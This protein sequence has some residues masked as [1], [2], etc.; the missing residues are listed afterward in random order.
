MIYDTD[1]L[2]YTKFLSGNQG[3]IINNELVWVVKKEE[4][5]NVFGQDL[6]QLKPDVSYFNTI[7]TYPHLPSSNI[8]KDNV[9]KY[10]PWALYPEG[11]NRHYNTPRYSEPDIIS[12]QKLDA[13]ERIHHCK[14]L[15]YLAYT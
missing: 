14:G 2:L 7:S 13:F 4:M 12:Y 11:M 3:R 1:S 15:P 5:G 8:A 9:Y 6:V 10:N